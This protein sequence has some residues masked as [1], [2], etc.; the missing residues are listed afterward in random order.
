MPDST[1]SCSI[2]DCELLASDVC[3]REGCPGDETVGE[4]AM[5]AL[6]N[7]EWEE[8]RDA[9]D[10]F[11]R[12]VDGVLTA[13]T[14]EVDGSQLSVLITMLNELALATVRFRTNQSIAEGVIIN[15]TPERDPE[16]PLNVH[17]DTTLVAALTAAQPVIA[18]RTSTLTEITTALRQGKAMHDAIA[19]LMTTT[20][21]TQSETDARINLA[22]TWEDLHR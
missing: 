21:G 9:I 22:R 20:P 2:T 11:D 1:A 4:P 6:P 8:Y 3:A 17:L 19:K 10:Y 5:I 18:L 13:D 14:I 7:L 15:S 16:I 12:L